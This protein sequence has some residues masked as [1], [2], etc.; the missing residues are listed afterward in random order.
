MN[1]KS[2]RFFIEGKDI[3]TLEKLFER[4]Y[5]LK[6]PQ[7]S[8]EVVSYYAQMIAQEL[9]LPSQFAALA[10]KV[11]DFLKCVAFGQEVDLDSPEILEAISRPLTQV[12]TMKVFLDG[13]RHTLVQDQVPELE[14]E[15]RWLSSVDPFPWSQEAPECSKTVFNK[16]PCDNKFEAR[17]C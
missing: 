7:T 11:R 8:Q 16:V 15:G 12:V 13:L 5:T 9:K 10:P 17:I 1:K 3:L 14:S 2:G 4:R 6:T